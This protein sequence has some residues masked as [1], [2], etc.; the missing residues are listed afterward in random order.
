MKRAC[1]WCLAQ[2]VPPLPPSPPLQSANKGA[3]G[4]NFIRCTF[5]RLPCPLRS[6][7]L[8]AQLQTP[9]P[10]AIPQTLL[11]TPLSP[12]PPPPHTAF[13]LQSTTSQ[14]AHSLSSDHTS[15]PPSLH[16]LSSI[17]TQ[18]C[19]T[20]TPLVSWPQPRCPSSTPLC[21]HLT[22]TSPPPPMHIVHRLVVYFEYDNWND[23]CRY[24][25]PTWCLVNGIGRPL[26]THPTHPMWRRGGG[27]LNFRGCKRKGARILDFRTSCE[28]PPPLSRSKQG[29]KLYIPTDHR[30]TMR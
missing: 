6:V 8:F 4:L 10:G 20:R 5:G 29:G 22:P 11:S 13:T 17:T 30:R 14:V 21:L 1:Y 26:C 18:L 15:S 9:F 27:V 7:A 23:I 3:L 19:P 25:L 28:P 12:P 2:I 16:P 24:P